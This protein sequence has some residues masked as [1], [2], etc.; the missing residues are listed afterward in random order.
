MKRKLSLVFLLFFSWQV[1]AQET[2]PVNGVQDK[3]PEIFA[4]TNANLVVSPGQT[5]TKGTL[6]VKKGKIEAAGKGVQVPDG[7]V[8]VDLEGKFIYPSFID[9]YTSYGLPDPTKS[10]NSGR[11]SPPQFVSKK[12]GAYHWN[13]AIRPEYNA[14]EQVGEDEKEA[15][16]LR[17]LGFGAV[18][19]HNKDGIARG[20]SVFLSLGNERENELILQ[21]RAAAHYS[22][23]KGSSGNDYP[24]SL[25][26]AIALL[27]QTWYD[28]GWYAG[29]GDEAEFNLSLNAFNGIQDLP[30]IFEV[31]GV[32][33]LLRAD[34]LGDEFGV[35]YVFRTGGDEYQRLEQVKAAGGSLIV[36]L[37]FTEA[38][39]VE[40]PY[41]AR[42][43]SLRQMKH[44]EL[45]PANAG[46]LA[47]AGIP[48]ALTSD[49]AVKDF[50]K[51]LRKAIEY[52]LPEEEALRALTRTPAAILGLEDKIGTLESGKV[53]NF[54]ITS[55]NVFDKD[56]VIY[57]NWVQGK[58]YVVN[59]L[60]FPDIRGKYTL[61]IQE[62]PGPWEMNV[63]GSPVKPAFEIIRGKEKIK[64]K[65]SRT[66]DLFSLWFAPEEAGTIRLN[67]SVNARDPLQLGGK[68]ALPGGQMTD[69]SARYTGVYEPEK[70]DTEEK[71]PET[72]PVIYPFTAFGRQTLPGP[73]KV[74]IKNAT[75]WTNEEEGVLENADVLIDGGKIVSV[76][77]SLNASGAT[78]IDANGKHVT[79]GIVDEHSHIAVARGINEATQSVTSEVRIGDNLN[80]EDVNIYRQL[81]GGVTTSH[82]LHGSANTIGGQT[83][84]IKLRWGKAPEEL[85]FKGADGFIK[86]ALGE[87]V[88]QSNWGDSQTTRFPQT[89]M[90]VEQVIVDA[91]QRAKEYE[92]ARASGKNV[93]RD[94]ELDALVE[95]LNEERFITCHSYVQSEINMLLKTADSMGFKVNT[96][97]HIL[98]GY[99]VA[100]KMK[101][102]G[103]AGSTFSDWWAY[104]MEVLDA[105]PYN[106]A[107]MHDVGVLAGIN[108]D[109]AE[110]ARRLNQEA[111]KAVKYGG[112]SEEEALKL[113][114]L[115][116]ARMLHIDDRVGSLKAGK[117]ADVVL[118]S[119]HPLSIYA[120]A[121]KT[122]VDGI[123]YFDM[124]E[125]AALREEVAKER[126]RLIQK[127]LEAKNKGEKTRKPEKK[128][129]ILYHCEDIFHFGG[130]FDDE[131]YNRKYYQNFE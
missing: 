63:S 60:D 3:R 98:E 109:D 58:K 37:K 80:S 11:G 9:L 102:H 30:Q 91:F 7:A 27:R 39:D 14:G 65:F 87:N 52:G 26:G 41:D 83:Q 59:D 84:L 69:W 119:D 73:E 5:I 31:T 97:T 96:L 118:W 15:D 75:I 104:K 107:L 19:S 57:E 10:G 112:L 72:G 36:P 28:A 108:S 47:E 48:F 12:K 90:G 62:G 85:K 44:W 25:M 42:Q 6:L 103:A 32:L 117:D 120:K 20:T 24:N 116:P 1:H 110:M 34:K 54:I 111:A 77:K 101:E 78:V 126:A 128:E 113:V 16:S 45:A 88:K 23:A 125:D 124:E 115:N 79:T 68:A 64:A 76:G 105:I 129:Q 71:E 93:R 8:V 106:A 13:E 114:T 46:R 70:K 17:D 86:F 51:N 49:G 21:D 22:F 43:V 66:G 95:I 29:G 122:W 35:Q 121:E 18:L 123:L 53:A 38:Y 92:K 2:F 131:E 56:Q 4:F 74:L 89:R 99:K 67:G 40:D 61:Q 130:G 100:D 50:W 127:M 82:I 81:S 94:L 55:G 33:D